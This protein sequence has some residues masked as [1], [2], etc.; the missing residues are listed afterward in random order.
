MIVI[1]T[2]SCAAF[3]VRDYNGTVN[4]LVEMN[5]VSMSNKTATQ[6]YRE[7]FILNKRQVIILL[8]LGTFLI[9]TFYCCVF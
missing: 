1:V 9:K 7:H 6:P 4:V 5:E 3:I 2:I 8:Y